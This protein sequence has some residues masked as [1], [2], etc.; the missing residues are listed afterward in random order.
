MLFRRT[1]IVA[2]LT[3]SVAFA[4]AQ[5]ATVDGPTLGR[6]ASIPPGKTQSIALR[7]D[8]G[9][10][11]AAALAGI[12]QWRIAP[13]AFV[14]LKLADGTYWQAGTVHIEHPDGTRVQIVGNTEAPE[15]VRL[16][17]A[18]HTD[19]IYVGAGQALGRLD[20]VTLFRD[21]PGGNDNGAKDNA[22]GLLAED[23]GTLRA[24]P[25]VIVDGFYYG[26]QAR[27]G[28]VMR[29][30]GTTVRRAGDAGFFAYSGGHIDA[31][32]AKAED[33][34]DSRL[35][36]GSGFVAEYGG[37]IDATGAQSKRNALAGFT[38]LSNGSIVANGASATENRRYGFYAITNG[39]IVAHHPKLA[40]NTVKAT[41]SE[42]GG[43]ISGI[44]IE[45]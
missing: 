26:A 33:V 44:G 19:G 23:A 45:P 6:P 22:I 10:S 42:Q 21:I 18:G 20:G 1:L 36:L 9:T 25:A 29:L 41:Q 24:G 32:Q 12:A 28:G 4:G 15:K 38:A 39:S 14:V 11:L 2:I 27:F 37:T 34:S 43:S 5:V 40:K 31:Q 35:G 7:P 3:G 8:G 17:W 13:G 16:I 30:R